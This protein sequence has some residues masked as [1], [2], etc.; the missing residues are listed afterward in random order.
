MCSEAVSDW[1]S[2]SC[3]ASFG[4]DSVTV[5]AT[6]HIPSVIPGYDGFG[7]ASKTATMPLDH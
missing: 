6:I 5:T 1:L 3:P 7:D 4:D 2:V